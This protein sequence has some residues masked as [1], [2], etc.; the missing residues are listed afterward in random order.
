MSI[1]VTLAVGEHA[2]TWSE[3]DVYLPDETPEPNYQ[4][5]A[6]KAWESENAHRSVAFLAMIAWD[7]VD[8]TGVDTASAG[9][10]G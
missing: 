5:D 7:Y 2:H 8:E 6:L 10:G 3:E 1:R 9:P 4:D